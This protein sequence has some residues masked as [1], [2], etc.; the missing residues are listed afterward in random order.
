M[1]KFRFW[2][3]AII[4]ILVAGIA[5]SNGIIYQRDLQVKKDYD[6]EIEFF[7][8]VISIVQEDYVD[9]QSIDPK[10]LI[11]GALEGMVSQLDPYSQFLE[12]D[13]FKDIKVETKGE[14]GG[15][16]IEITIKDGL[17]TIVAPID[18]TPAAKA[19]IMPGDRVVKI[20]GKPTKEIKLQDAVKKLR[21]RPGSIVKITVLREDEKRLIDF[22][23]A[24]AV[25]KVESVKNVKIIDEGYKIGY[26]KLVEFQERT[27]ADLETAL[28]KLKSE[29]MQALVL[30]LR[31][32]P[33][34]LLETAIGVAEKFIPKGQLIVSTKGAISAQNMVFKS[35]GN[36]LYTVVPMVVLVN[37]GSASA[38]EIVAGAIQDYRRGLILGT[39]TFGKGSVQ[40]VIPLVDG[41]ALRLTT[42]R[43]YTPKNKMI[44]HDGI[45]PDVVV[46]K[47]ELTQKKENAG[48]I[49]QDMED[50]KQEIKKD[51]Y[52]NQLYRAVDLLKGIKIYKGF[53]EE[54]ASE[55]AKPKK[56]TE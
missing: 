50:Q 8:D 19:G 56:A 6:K 24:R 49:F 48:E 40:T 25:I 4:L 52:D 5:V 7:K 42:A 21:G 32:N 47:E 12:P 20:D 46:E 13:D 39:N 27:P 37:K 28:A 36:N 51:V 10:K 9:P 14:F 44:P 3:L 29:G 38:S 30:D 55:N 41:S 23:I 45:K 11:Y 53:L 2:W 35:N 18:G 16:G 54:A 26:I 43:Y 22:A 31:N 17:L 1:R 34:G 33:G 15:L